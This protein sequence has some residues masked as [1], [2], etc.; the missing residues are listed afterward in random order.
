MS[1]RSV[2]DSARVLRLI[3]IAALAL[4]VIAF[5][6]SRLG[7]YLGPQVMVVRQGHG[8]DSL[9]ANLAATDAGVLL[10]AVSLAQLIRLLGRLGSGELF[11]PAVTGAFRTF[12]FWLLLSAAVAIGGPL[13]AGLAGALS[14]AS[15]R[16]EFRISIRDVM[17]LVASLVIFLVARMFDEAARIESELEEIV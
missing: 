10:F 17:F 15:H 6:I 2:A 1:R 8:A 13:L 3:A 5:V 11:G 7:L 4:I 16:A 12:A 14:D 9:V